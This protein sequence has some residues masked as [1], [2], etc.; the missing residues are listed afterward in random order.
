MMQLRISRG[1]VAG[2]SRKDE[3]YHEK[4]LREGQK[5]GLG[6]REGIP[7]DKFGFKG[8]SVQNFGNSWWKFQAPWGLLGNVI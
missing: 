1:E 7:G 5:P 3:Q 2:H 4:G 8:S 6:W